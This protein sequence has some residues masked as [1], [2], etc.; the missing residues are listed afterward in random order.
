LRVRKKPGA[1]EA[2]ASIEEFFIEKPEVHKG[3]WQSVFGNNHPIYAEFGGG[4]GRF[5]VGM[6]R[7]H[8]EINF[9]MADAVTEVALKAAELARE[10]GLENVKIILFDLRHVLDIFAEGEL[11]RIYLNFSDPWP[12]RRH[13][14]RRLTYRGFLSNYKTVL[15]KDGWIHFKT[16]NRSLFEFS[17]NEFAELDLIMRKISLDLHKQDELDNVMTEYEEKFSSQ[18]YPIFR[19]EVRFR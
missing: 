9:I 19:V 8:P 6:A 16:D 4:K 10:S 14:K 13:Y 3:A 18:G 5:I 11:D 17:L 15:K 7:K 2:L 12:K 1:Y